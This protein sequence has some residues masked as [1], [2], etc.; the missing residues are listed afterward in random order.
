MV[1]YDELGQQVGSVEFDY[2]AVEQGLAEKLLPEAAQHP[3]ANT[4]REVKAVQSVL[5]WIAQGV[6]KNGNGIEIRATIMM[7]KFLPYLQPKSLTE[8]AAMVGRDKQSL[9]RWHDD[10]KRTFGTHIK[11]RT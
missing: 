9:G 3:N 7:W 8:M 11:R 4:D 5:R 2:D 10:F 1:A 6:P